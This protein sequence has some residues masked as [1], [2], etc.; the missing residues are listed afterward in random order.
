MTG[1]SA[2]PDACS[3]RPAGRDVPE[4]GVGSADIPND[5]VTPCP[6][7]RGME[8]TPEQ[9]EAVRDAVLTADG[10]LMS[11]NR[12]AAAA[13]LRLAAEVLHA[14]ADELEARSAAD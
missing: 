3:G 10:A 11:P 1:S 7:L 14:V 5:V 6:T 8:P 13:R 2:G 9:A 12:E 4:L